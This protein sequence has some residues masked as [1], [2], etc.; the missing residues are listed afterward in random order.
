MEKQRTINNSVIHA[1]SMSFKHLRYVTW[2]CLVPG[3]VQL[4]CEDMNTN[5]IITDI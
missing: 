2:A 1:F 5:M 4:D 3:S